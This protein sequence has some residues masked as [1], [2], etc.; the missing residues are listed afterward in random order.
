MPA[1]Q[2]HDCVSS[3]GKDGY[4][5][6]MNHDPIL[7]ALDELKA[8]MTGMT[9]RID[10][11]EAGKTARMDRLEAGM[12][13]RIDRLE[14]GMTTR[15]DRLEAGQIA[16]RVDLMER[17]DRLQDSLTAGRDDIGVNMGAVDAMQRANDNTRE[18]VR[19]QGE[20]MTVMWRQLK[21]LEAKVRE[22]TGDP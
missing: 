5:G 1:Y 9:T 10:R 18:L 4:D 14:A 7:A 17:M 11:L 21:N 8:G 16:T 3:E 2:V 22:I 20:Q 13:T 15:I 6:A 19:A 12:T